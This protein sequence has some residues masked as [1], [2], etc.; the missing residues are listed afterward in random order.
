MNYR[1]IIIILACISLCVPCYAQDGSNWDD[2]VDGVKRLGKDKKLRQEFAELSE[3]YQAVEIDGRVPTG[4][5]LYMTMA[6]GVYS[7]PAGSKLT[8]LADGETVLLLDETAESGGTAWQKIKFLFI[9]EF[10]NNAV[11]IDE[12]WVEKS[13]LKI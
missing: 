13:S 2:L 6:V 8:E 7:S 12:G 5:G 1:S 10:S 3:Q 4:G 9:S 11:S